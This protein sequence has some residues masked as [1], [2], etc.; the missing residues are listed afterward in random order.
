MDKQDFIEVQYKG[1]VYR[2]YMGDSAWYCR[3]ERKA[4][5]VRKGKFVTEV[6]ARIAERRASRD[7]T[8]YLNQASAATKNYERKS[9]LPGLTRQEADAK[10]REHNDRIMRIHYQRAYLTRL[11]RCAGKSGVELPF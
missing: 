8:A 2:R 11:A 5:T 9:L 1:K 10:A 7:T 3:F 4:H 6:P